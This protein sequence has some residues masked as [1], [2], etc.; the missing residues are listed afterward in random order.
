[1]LRQDVFKIHFNFSNLK[2]VFLPVKAQI[3]APLYSRISNE[4]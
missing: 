3:P 1:M 2:I 4:K